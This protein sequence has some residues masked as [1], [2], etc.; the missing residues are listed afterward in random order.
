MRNEFDDRLRAHLQQLQERNRQLRERKEQE[1]ARHA[2]RLK[3]ER[4]FN[5][6]FSNANKDRNVSPPPQPG[7]GDARGIAVGVGLGGSGGADARSAAGERS[8]WEE[9]TV[10]ILGAD[11][12]VH[13]TRPD[14]SVV[15]KGQPVAPPDAGG[16]MAA[17]SLQAPGAECDPG[18]EAALTP[19]S[20]SWAVPGGVTDFAS[21]GD[22]DCEVPD[23]V[24][25]AL[26]ATLSATQMELREV[27]ASFMESHGNAGGSIPDVDPSAV[28][29]PAVPPS[30]PRPKTPAA[31]EL[32]SRIKGLPGDWR[33]ALV[34]LLEEAED[35][36]AGGDDHVTHDPAA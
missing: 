10:E 5:V 29:E 24:D 14:G 1:E 2:D 28:Q 15:S 13:V 23:E 8:V 16:V 17:E 22:D 35:K 34:R 19:L 11:G 27:W 12:A 18:R 21:D 7:P 6:H 9:R 31:E 26:K 36:A 3:R 33:K 20:A 4:G 32:A 25:E 30:P